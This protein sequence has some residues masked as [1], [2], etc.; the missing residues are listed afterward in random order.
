M[1]DDIIMASAAHHRLTA[2]LALLV[3]ALGGVLLTGLVRFTF[4]PPPPA[5]HYHANWAVFLN[6]Q[7]LDL[8]SDRLMEDVANC[9]AD[10][11]HVSP[12][13]RVHM[14]NGDADAVH[15]HDAGATWGHLLANIDF[16]VGDDYLVTHTGDRLLTG[17]GRTLKFVLNS[18]PIASIRNVGID[19]GDRLL[20]SY[21]AEPLDTV[22][23]TQFPNVAS[24]AATLDGSKDPAGCGGAASGGFRDRFRRAFWF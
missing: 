17:A 20:I 10:P 13:E 23:R 24:T 19:R 3:G 14:H 12:E 8:S 5:V 7:R 9:K 11:T 22:V 4:Q 2:P 6:G 1:T 18:Q 21:G 15:V 16:G